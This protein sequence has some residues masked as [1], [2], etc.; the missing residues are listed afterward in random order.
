MSEKYPQPS[1]QGSEL[2]SEQLERLSI[3]DK[4]TSQV[5][6]ML[7]ENYQ[8]CLTIGTHYTPELVVAEI[9]DGLELVNLSLFLPHDQSSYSP[10]LSAYRIHRSFEVKDG[11]GELAIKQLEMT[12]VK[13]ND[14]MRN[15]QPQVSETA[16]QE[17]IKLE[18]AVAQYET[19]ALGLS[20]VEA[21]KLGF[22]YTFIR[23]HF[24]PD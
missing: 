2:S 15:D 3:F 5:G 20:K 14:L 4:M 24:K 21:D 9:D 23:N 1:R 12:S 11:A 16:N 18:M 17:L 19:L 13:R 22:S 6:D 10:E 7:S 8:H